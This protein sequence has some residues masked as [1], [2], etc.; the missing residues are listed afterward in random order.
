MEIGTLKEQA[1]ETSR[2]RH[3]ARQWPPQPHKYPVTFSLGETVGILKDINVN[4]LNYYETT[5]R[6]SAELDGSDEF[7][8]VCRGVKSFDLSFYV[9]LNVMSVGDEK[10]QEVVIMFNGLNEIA[11]RHY[12]HY[13]RLGASL[14]LNGIGAVL[15]TTP[16][17]LNRTPYLERKFRKLYEERGGSQKWPDSP[18]ADVM[19]RVPHR[20]VLRNQESLFHSFQQ[21]ATEVLDFAS[22]L[23]V[24]SIKGFITMDK[25]DEIFY[26]ELFDR[27][28]VRVSLLGYSLG[29]L[30]ALYTYLKD[31]G[32]FGRCILVNSGASVDN[33]RTKPVGITDGEWSAIRQGARKA[34]YHLAEMINVHDRGFLDDV[35]FERPFKNDETLRV[36]GASSNNLL[37]IAGGADAVSPAEYLLQF[38][39][40]G[41][42]SS[43]GLNILQVEGLEHPLQ[44]S[45][46]YDR[47]FPLIVNTINKFLRT[48][49][50]RKSEYSYDH[51]IQDLL[52]VK[53]AGQ[54]WDQWCRDKE[55]V[56]A[57][58]QNLNVE[59]ILKQLP[60]L[61]K[62]EFFLNYLYSKRYFVTDAEL[63]RTLDRERPRE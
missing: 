23:R 3:G 14:A 18:G 39:P 29:G 33:L 22:Y 53:I 4:M 47:W 59:R 31:P 35:L 16:F 8:W 48:P 61:A 2:S 1:K 12:A 36:F 42:G 20:G 17:H 40:K 46:E 49:D 28:N 41:G 24:R 9:P 50:M 44:R 7:H 58:D 55:L 11:N 27:K 19:M 10:I 32:L 63:L 21:L 15:Y 30:Q 13:D 37:F 6:K 45:L 56:D 51:V 34:K 38:Q 25:D 62:P 52:K 57:R 5:V 60:E 26:E 54:P 43:R